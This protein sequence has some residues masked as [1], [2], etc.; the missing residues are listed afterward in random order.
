M[1]VLQFIERAGQRGGT[2]EEIADGLALNANAERPRRLELEEGGWVRD[3]G[4]KRSTRSGNDAIVWVLTDR[5]LAQF[6]VA[7]P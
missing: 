4:Q 7:A 5:A 3:S 1:R 2:D 6:R